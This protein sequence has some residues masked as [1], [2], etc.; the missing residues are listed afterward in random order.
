MSLRRAIINGSETDRNEAIARLYKLDE[1]FEA[2]LVAADDLSLAVGT[3]AYFDVILGNCLDAYFLHCKESKELLRTTGPIGNF[4]S[5]LACCRAL[6]ILDS[7]LVQALRIAAEIRNKFA[8]DLE[9]TFEEP[10]ISD[11][12]FSLVSILSSK[13]EKELRGKTDPKKRLG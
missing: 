11:R 7:E 12:C 9:I 10:A 3:V 2:K 6:R 4:N 13:S 1:I 8:H 5:R